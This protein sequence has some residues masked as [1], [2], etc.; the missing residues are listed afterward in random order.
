MTWR[1]QVLIEGHLT[2]AAQATVSV[3]P[4]TTVRFRST[5]EGVEGLLLVR[6][7]LQAVGTPE[8]PV[9]FTADGIDPAPDDWQGILFLDSSKKNLLEWCR[10]EAAA[11]GVDAEYSDLTMR[12]TTIS[13]SRTGVAIRS[14]SGV[15]TGGGVTDCTTGFTCAF[16]DA[17]VEDIRLSGNFR[18]IVITGGSLFLSASEVTASQGNGIEASGARLRL[19][20]NK[21]TRNGAGLVLKECRGDVVSNGIEENRT[22]GLDLTD[23][24]LRIIGNWITGNGEAGVMIRAGGGT[25]WDNTLRGNGGYELINAGPEEVVAPGNWW[26]S[27]DLAEVRGRIK[28]GCADRS[29][30]RVTLAPLL[31]GPPS[32]GP[33]QSAD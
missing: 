31:T 16:G 33:R 18:G 12:N 10:V 25:L 30:G 6:G 24:P 26:G 8:K 21:V 1:G 29:C 5:A 28:E 9:L 32:S 22:Y 23:A 17:D 20:G 13:R 14:S 3:S 19:E 11:T 15:I 4:G 7:R 27:A 2:I